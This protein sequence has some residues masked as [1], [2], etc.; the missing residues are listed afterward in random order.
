MIRSLLESLGSAA[1]RSLTGLA[2]ALAFMAFGAVGTAA[3]TG[4]VTGS[5]VNIVSQTA[6][7]GAQVSVLGTSIGGLANNVGRYLIL[8]VPAGQHTIRVQLIGFAT[9]EQTVTVTAGE[10]AAADFRL[11]QQA[12][13]LE[14]VIVTGTAG[15]ARRREIGNT[16]SQISVEDIEL[17]TVTD[18]GDILQGRVTGVQINDH[19]GQVGGG[20]MIR[21]RGNSSL[22]QGNFP[23][24]YIDGLRME[25]SAIMADD[26]AGQ[27]ASAFDMINPNDIERIEIIKGPAAT[28]LYGTEAAGGVI[29]I[30]TKRGSAGAPA[31]TFNMD[32]GIHSMKHQAGGINPKSINPTGYYLNDC[33][34]RR[35]FDTNTKEF[36]TINER[37]AGCPE[38]GSWFKNGFLQRYNLSV[39]G[40]GET[41]TYFVSG[42]WENEEGVVDPQGL[43][44][45]GVRAN[46]S[47]QPFDGLDISLNNSY[48]H[49]TITW[50]PDGNN[51]S[52][53]L[54]NVLRGTAGY[55]PQNDDSKVFE[56]DILSIIDQYQLSANINWSPNSTW[57][58]RLN[59]GLDYTVNDFIDWKYWDYYAEPTGDREDDQRQDRN[60]TFDY[61]GTFN[62]SPLSDVTSHFAF[63]GQL[64]EEFNYRLNGFDER[65]AGPGEPQL[66][67]GT[68]PG[69]FENRL[70]VRSGG[71]FLQEQ[72][73][74][75]DKVFVTAGVRWDGFSTFGEGFGLAT[76][77]KLSGTYLISDESFWP[78]VVE[79]LK[80]RV[81][82]G[83]S[84]RAPGAFDAEKLWE[85]TQADE[86][87]P[88]VVINNLGNPDLGPEKS[89][90]LEWG[91]DATAY[92]GR[93][94]VEFTKYD[95]TTADALIRVSP[96]P[97]TGT[98]NRVL[99]NLGEMKNWGTELSVQVV[100]VRSDDI[101]WALGVQ[102]STNDS[103]VT[104]LGPLKDLGST[105]RLGLPLRIRWDDQLIVC[106]RDND[107]GE[108]CWDP[109]AAYD[110]SSPPKKGKRFIGRQF[111][112]DL[113]NLTTRL[114]L[115]RSLTLDVVG[116]GQY[117]MFLSVGPAYQ[118]MRRTSLSNPV[119]PYCAP[120]LDTWNS[121]D[122]TSLTN[123]QVVECVQ[124][125]SDQGVWT[126]KADFFR[127]RSTTLAWRVPDR[128]V[129]GGAR[130]VRLSLQGKN[131][132]TFTD[133]V[134]LDPEGQDNGLS[135]ATPNDYY[136]Y[137]P[138]R[139]FLFGV[140]VT[141]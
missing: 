128:W 27:E 134:G 63:G 116:E 118:N 28:T 26:E 65:F 73:G 139:T 54:L 88:A 124:K 48:Q 59:V 135:D 90:E 23:L 60:L 45:Y 64:Y 43:N 36:V 70:R 37:Q 53:F 2:M 21:L 89:T 111:P 16:I 77:P 125:F 112:T 99:R 123:Q 33:T 14:G 131:M 96:T 78:G 61:A 34:V 113:L 141:F 10:V 67:D 7:A 119:W 126:R 102:W 17:T 39:R 20:S 11:R 120:I 5:V 97:S 24:I 49:K 94:T 115:F 4:T 1:T 44:A 109:V 80:L 91:F 13:A 79:T 83:Q 46:V 110:P 72:L 117:G 40:G 55:T 76:Y 101:E 137:G 31:W 66:G 8:N 81:A 132:L 68:N 121:G 19:G 25:N 74:W 107:P 86:Q 15:Q 62:Y 51:A 87:Q 105:I 100:P 108:A 47:F 75:Q 52:G 32:G 130:S 138:P 140:R 9:V 42:R 92:G 93:L 12:L 85:A 6:L 84:G 95:Q 35:E 114:T 106:G 41:A 56:N 133:Y 58:H 30:F 69:I 57:A 136:T 122:R 104:D 29:Q 18:L 71:A 98:N 129:P 22:T 38:S 103:E 82:W 50:I 127:L 3:Q